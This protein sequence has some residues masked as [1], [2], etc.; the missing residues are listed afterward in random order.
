[1]S[2]AVIAAIITGSISL[3]GIIITNVVSAKKHQEDQTKF[4]AELF[5][6][7]DKQSELAD[8][9]IEAKIDRIQAVTNEKIDELSRRVEK[10]NNLIERTYR[11]E[12]NSAVMAEK[13]RSM[14]D[15]VEDLERAVVH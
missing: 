4:V 1:M 5:A 11:L 14:S 13:I 2:P 8:A 10:H 7:L 12:E 9:K 3:L 6:K 15:K